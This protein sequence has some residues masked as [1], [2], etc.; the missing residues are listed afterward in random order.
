MKKH[1]DPRMKSPTFWRRL[2][3]PARARLWLWVSS[4]FLLLGSGCAEVKPWER[5]ILA[6]Y[7]MIPGRD[8]VGD[9]QKEHVYFSR[10][11]A[12]GGHAVGGSGCGCN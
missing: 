11:E 2:P 4:V 1:P 12:T 6:D 8:P 3:V 10:E 7:I 5:G 9:M